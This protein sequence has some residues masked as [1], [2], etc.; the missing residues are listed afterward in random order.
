MYMSVIKRMSI[1]SCLL[2]MVAAVLAQDWPAADS[3]VAVRPVTLTFPMNQTEV[4]P[5]IGDNRQQLEAIGRHIDDI[6]HDDGKLLRRITIAGYASPDGRHSTNVRMA[7]ERAEGVGSY[8]VQQLQ[9]DRQLIE[10]VVGAEDWEGLTA[11]ISRCTTRQ[12]PHRSALLRIAGS[13]LSA[14]RKEWLIKRR[15]PRDYSYL[16]RHVF[17][18]LRRA[19]CSIEY[20]RQEVAVTPCD[21][22]APPPAADTTLT[23]PPPREDTVAVSLP[24][25]PY[26]PLLALKT[27]MLFDAALALNAEVEVPLGH[28]NRW[29]IMAEVW[30]PWFVWHS[31]SRA[32]QLQVLGVEGRYWLGAHRERKASL[33]GL[34]VGAYYANG[35]Y[36]FE[37]GSVGDQGEFNSVGATVGYSWPL[38]R[39]WNLELSASAGYFSGPR[40]HYHGEYDDTHLIWKYSA[41][42][43]YAGPTKLKLSLVWL[44]GRQ[45][46]KGGK[47][48]GR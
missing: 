43:S 14:D 47:E 28:S 27:N 22:V 31:N 23:L 30:K 29:S 42:T 8:L 32:Y 9:V 15:Y 46:P 3:L 38:H 44:L 6:Q 34:F 36:D 16:K 5:A 26:R 19:D 11:H 12:L 13:Q 17:P 37:W 4:M 24:E 18:R 33:T 2:A 39:H 48:A 1:I 25:T 21:T 20:S 10:T 40:R 41:T 35:K 7:R 45:R